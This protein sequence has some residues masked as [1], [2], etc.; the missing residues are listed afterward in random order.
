MS[1]TRRPLRLGVSL[2]SYRSVAEL[3]HHARRAEEIG[4][5]VVLL[6]DYLG[7]TAPL[8]PLVAVAQAAPSLRVSNLVINAGFLPANP[9]GARSG[10]CRCADRW[11]S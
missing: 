2:P 9:A 11:P 1:A 4:I 6:P 5:D 7:H 8:P 3:L 10:H